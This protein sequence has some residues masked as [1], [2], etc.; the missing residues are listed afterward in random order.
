MGRITHGNHQK[1]IVN[2]HDDGEITS[3]GFSP[4]LGKSIAFARIS[5]DVSGTCKV[6]M[7]GQQMVATV[8][9]LPFVRNG[10]SVQ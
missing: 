6:E 8:V 10:K 9:K 2:G 3:G 5:K 1:V 7:R 4:T